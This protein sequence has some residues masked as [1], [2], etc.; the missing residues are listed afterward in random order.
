MSF[1]TK[2]FGLISIIRT[3]L[4][5][6]AGQGTSLR[7]RLGTNIKMEAERAAFWAGVPLLAGVVTGVAV[8]DWSQSASDRES[9]FGGGVV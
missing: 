8:G 3:G 6:E 4:S 9:D 1:E 5:Q 7:E 2:I